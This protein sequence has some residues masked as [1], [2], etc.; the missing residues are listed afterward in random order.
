MGVMLGENKNCDL[1]PVK[2][3]SYRCEEK[4][5]YQKVVD[6]ILNQCKQA[7]KI[8]HVKTEDSVRVTF[9][10]TITNFG[11]ATSPVLIPEY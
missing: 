1:R 7:Y 11:N 5:A 3:P 8:T 4:V 6:H 9:N 10:I 2:C